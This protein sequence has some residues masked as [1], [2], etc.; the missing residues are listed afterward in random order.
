M[1]V[2][3]SISDAASKGDIKGIRIMMKNSMLVDP[4]LDE[5]FE[6]QKLT[7]SIDGLYDRHDGRAFETDKAAWD[8]DYMNKIMVQVVG[9]FSHERL[10]H[11]Q[12][13]IKYLRPGYQSK[14]GVSRN[15]Y[16]HTAEAEIHGQT[17]RTSYQEQKRQDAK[18]NRIV[19]SRSRKIV[20]G[21]VAGGVV[22]GA[23]AAVAGGSVVTGV[24]IGSAAVGAVVATTTNGGR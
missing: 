19:S 9:N 23:V 2:A 6:M 8:D 16:P 1:T 22:G 10:K 20:A 11:L 18:N 15:N 5:F 7:A 4:T 12:D 14:Q 13:V 3:K 21:A 17:Q 24:I